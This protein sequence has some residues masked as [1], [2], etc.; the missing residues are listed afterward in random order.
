M[1]PHEHPVGKKPVEAI[2]SPDRES[3]D[4]KTKGE[5]LLKPSAHSRSTTVIFLLGFLLFLIL[6]WQTGLEDIGQL[7]LDIGWLIP[8]VWVPFIFVIVCNSWAWWATFNEPYHHLSF[9]KIITISIL[10][11]AIQL[12]TPSIAQAGELLKIHLLRAAG[13]P[14]DIGIAS[15]VSAKTTIILTELL[16]IGIGLFLLPQFLSFDSSLLTSLTIGLVAISLLLTGL[17]I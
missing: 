14:A 11:Q 15:V 8:L 17:I 1:K 2:P 6:M 4:S 5:S 3:L 13:V 12:I 7:V 10:A 16:F 9:L